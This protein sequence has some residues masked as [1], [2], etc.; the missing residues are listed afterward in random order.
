MNPDYSSFEAV[1]ITLRRLRRYCEDLEKLPTVL[2][3]LRDPGVVAGH[4]AGCGLVH[5]HHSRLPTE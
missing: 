4:T 1:L 5:D 3:V 2:L